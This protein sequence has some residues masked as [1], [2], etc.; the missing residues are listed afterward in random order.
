[1]VVGSVA[2]GLSDDGRVDDD[3]IETFRERCTVVFTEVSRKT[4]E[5]YSTIKMRTNQ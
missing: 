1:V 4:N 2:L 3:H 5:I